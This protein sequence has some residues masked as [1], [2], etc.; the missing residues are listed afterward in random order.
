VD[1]EDCSEVADGVCIVLARESSEEG[2][3][4]VNKIITADDE[5]LWTASGSSN[6]SRWRIPKRPV[7]RETGDGRDLFSDSTVTTKRIS[8]GVEPSWLAPPS[9]HQG[10]VIFGLISV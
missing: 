4:G 9:I 8:T 5:L 2:G 6:I 1:V 3:E 7:K 10:N